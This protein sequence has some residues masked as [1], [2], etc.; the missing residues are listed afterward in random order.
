[1]KINQFNLGNDYLSREE[2]RLIKGGFVSSMC[3][4]DP[5]CTGG[6]AELVEDSWECSGCCIAADPNPPEIC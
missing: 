6:C 1:M 2:M 5:C 4:S 3:V